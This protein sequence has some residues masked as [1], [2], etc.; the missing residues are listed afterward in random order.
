MAPLCRH[1]SVPPPLSRVMFAW[2]GQNW[3]KKVNFKY[4]PSANWR[5]HCQKVSP[6]KFIMLAKEGKGFP[7]KVIHPLTL[8]KSCHQT[9]PSWRSLLQATIFPQ[10]ELTMNTKKWTPKHSTKEFRCFPVS[11]YFSNSVTSLPYSR[12]SAAPRETL[13]SVNQR[14]LSFSCF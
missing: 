8:E 9:C 11:R 3:D 14:I 2:R 6:V 13:F 4:Y 1:L 5:H 10:G 7:C 12:L